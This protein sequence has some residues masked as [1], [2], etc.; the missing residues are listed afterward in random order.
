MLEQIAQQIGNIGLTPWLRR[1]AAP[2]LGMLLAVPVHGGP[3]GLRPA[4]RHVQ[5]LMREIRE[6]LERRELTEAFERYRDYTADRLDASAGDLRFADKTGNCRLDWF[7]SLLRHPIESI[8]EAEKF[9]WNLHQ[10]AR[11]VNH[12]VRRVVATAA[13]K[14][15]LGD[16]PARESRPAA[17]SPDE[18]LRI[19]A[20]TLETAAAAL[21][22]AF[23]PLADEEHQ[24]LRR[25]LYPQSTGSVVHG[26]RFADT[27]LGRRTTD[28]LERIDHAAL[29]ET[30]DRLADLTDHVLLEILAGFD[31][32]EP[33]TVDGV[34][35]YVAMAIE[36]KAGRLLVGGRENNRYDLEALDDVCAIIDLGGDDTYIEGTTSA[37]R[38]LL[39][40]IDLGGDDTFK[41]EQPGIQGGA[42]LGASLLVSMGGNDRFEAGDVAQ[43]SALGGIGILVNAGGNNRY[44]GVRRVQGQAVGGLGM[45]LDRAGDDA[46][47]A[48]LLSQGVGGPLGFG[49]LIDLAGNDHYFAGGLYPN[50]YGDSPGFEGW[51]QGVG[52]GP[53]GVANGGLG[54]M[55][56]GGG[57]DVYEYDYFSHGGGYWFGAGFVR[58]FG[59]NNQRVGATRTMFDGSERTERRFVRWGLG[60]GCHYALGFVF[61]DEG[62]DTYIGET[63]SIAFAWDIAVGVV[64]DFG[65]NDLYQARGAGHAANAGLG[66]LFDASGD[67]SYKARNL[68]FANEKVDYHPKEKAGGNFAF[69]VD[70][71][72]DDDFGETLEN[73]SESEQGWPG[74]FFISRPAP[75]GY[76]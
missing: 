70:Y 1:L 34:D 9:T 6:G 2:C 74:G 71:G 48:A 28:L 57:D 24:E 38:P 44:T 55:L 36:T 10:D 14:L 32:A 12:G 20:Q 76:E 68:G 61:D 18:A 26:H 29:L 35:G 16:L 40:I 62:D 37:D 58:N 65:G 66:V 43:G 46:Y 11:D 3:E 75:P 45:L 5:T 23:A 33:I 52:T 47:R 4:Q 25:L 42:V 21:D 8:G 49:A 69:L 31:V 22:R 59:G 63:A 39:V 53:R 51:S 7:D 19:V 64:A 30:A 67:D 73:N 41:G 72:G 54:I 17:G 15:D 50:G 13:Q 56:D 60:Y 27:T